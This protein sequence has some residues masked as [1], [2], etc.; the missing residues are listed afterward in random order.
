LG[1]LA[2]E[3]IRTRKKTFA[4]PDKNSGRYNE[5][6]HKKY[7]KPKNNVALYFSISVFLSN[8]FRVFRGRNN[9]SPAEARKTILNV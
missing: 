6:D 5:K 7:K 2:L 1:L 4:L 9:F 3:I 8:F